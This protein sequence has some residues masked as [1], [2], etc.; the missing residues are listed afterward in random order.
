MHAKISGT[1]PETASA[2]LEKGSQTKIH[3]KDISDYMQADQ[4]VQRIEI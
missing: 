3:P 4:R 2:V 1:I